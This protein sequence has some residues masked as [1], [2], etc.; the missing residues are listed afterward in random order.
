MATLESKLI[1]SLI[2]KISGP[3]KGVN[4]AVGRMQSAIAANNQKLS[5]AR[6]QMIDAAAA[7]WV[8]YEAIKAPTE[9]AIAWNDA[10]SDIK[11]V[12]DFPTPT[13]LQ[14]LGA[15][16]RDMSLRIP[17]AANDLAKLAAAGGQGGIATADLTKFTEMASKVGVAWD[18][19]GQE[20]G[21]ALAELK[22]STGRTLDG[23]IKLAD[24]INYLGNNTAASAS[25]ILD[26]TLRAAPMAQQFGFTTEQAAA[27]GA[28]MESAGFQ[29]DVAATSFNNM[30]A[31]LTAG[32]SA[33]KSQLGAYKQLGLDYRKV[34]K[35]MQK[36]AVGTMRDV[37]AR[38]NKVKPEKRAALIRQLFGAEARALTPLI[39]N[40]KLLEE[41]LSYI[42]DE[43]KYAG[44][45]QREF[46]IASQRS[47]FALQMLRNEV[48]D[49][50]VEIGQAFEPAVV[51]GTEALKPYIRSIKTW[52]AANHQMTTRIA[53]A[54]AGFIGLNIAMTAARYAGLW[55][56]GNLLM[57]AAGGL[58][59]VAGAARIASLAFLPFGAALRGA[60]T[61]MIGFAAAAKIGGI[62][63]A[64][65]TMGASLLG[66]LNPLRLFRVAIR[67]VG[68]ALRFAFVSSGVG[69]IIAGIVAAGVF[70]YKNWDGV[71]E[72]FS[73]F[74][75]SFMNALGPA[76]PL[77]EKFATAVS[78]IWKK[79]TG[80]LGP[81]DESGAKWRAWGE[82]LGALAGGGVATLIE[83]LSKVGGWLS[84]LM[85][86]AG[87]AAK[88]IG[89]V[90]SSGGGPN[91]GF[92]PPAGGY[93][94]DPG[95]NGMPGVG[96]PTVDGARAAG[97]PVSAGR[98]Y[99]TGELGPE[100]FTPRRSGYV[101][102]AGETAGMAGAT[103]IEVGGIHI[104]TAPGQSPQD[105]ARAV[106]HELDAKLARQRG[107]AFVRTY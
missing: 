1:V 23:T 62:G 102:D 51:A 63:T 43:S 57:A 11:K 18:L 73:S 3:I 92:S 87:S 26:F 21:Q 49:L 52:V 28:G 83:G 9:A 34:A 71:G 72:M 22:T 36:D 76:K 38:I 91:N 104:T 107:G 20:A 68:I 80:L 61:A 60:R 59:V 67:G 45:A 106:M 39:T 46:E 12:V 35:G 42:A 88:A 66:L 96:A 65:S 94:P 7:G 29:A 17:M 56:K 77:V 99:L 37:F 15:V 53:A 95:W 89:N 8:L 86:L 85:E 64:L 4:A 58:R 2:D 30:G 54:S 14:E 81:I 82:R 50:S 33:T 41:V 5:V 97:G 101:H 19:S 69:A 79:I 13:G 70:I 25:R 90:F 40:G 32:E 75:K 6:G 84:R 16:I 10:L 27:L 47:K 78:T 100:L 98:T 105:I 48:V 55:L 31:A 93:K 103:T 74:G 24:A 44:S